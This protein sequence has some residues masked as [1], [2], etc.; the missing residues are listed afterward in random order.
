MP[1]HHPSPTLSKSRRIAALAAGVC[2]DRLD[3]LTRRPGRVPLPLGR[4]NSGGSDEEN[5]GLGQGG[6]PAE[7]VS[8]GMCSLLVPH[9]WGREDGAD[10]DRGEASGAFGA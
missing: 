7:G 10:P 6:W 8:V 2:V 9:L 1:G 3:T 4:E 5:N